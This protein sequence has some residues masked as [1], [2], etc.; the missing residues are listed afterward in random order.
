MAQPVIF[1]ALPAILPGHG[2]SAFSTLLGMRRFGMVHEL[3]GSAELIPADAACELDA[4]TKGASAQ[5]VITSL[6]APDLGR[7]EL[8]RHFRTMG[9][10]MIAEHLAEAWSTCMH[11]TTT[12]AEEI[13]KWMKDHANAQ[14]TYVVIDTDVHR[15]EL[16]KSDLAQNTV[17]INGCVP[18]Y[19]D[20]GRRVIDMLRAQSQGRVHA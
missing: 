10:P 11:T 14:D 4:I 16:L 12:R 19:E 2:E 13:S 20:L 17:I 1:V 5:F 8:A 7:D 15:T 9:M 3:K 6:F 18:G